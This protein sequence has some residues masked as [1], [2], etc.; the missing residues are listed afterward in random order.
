MPRLSKEGLASSLL[1]CLLADWGWAR[2]EAASLAP[3]WM[4]GH[5]AETMAP[6]T[7]LNTMKLAKMYRSALQ[8]ELDSGHYSECDALRFAA[9]S[10]TRRRNLAW[11]DGTVQKIHKCQRSR[12]LLLQSAIHR[13]IETCPKMFDL[14]QVLVS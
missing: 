11:E 13:L 10:Q 7:A 9:R 4:P 1:L 8:M 14:A 3:F 2:L 6:W 5:L 12:S